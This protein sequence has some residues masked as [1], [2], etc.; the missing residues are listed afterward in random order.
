MA[1]ARP[2]VEG[3]AGS[4]RRRERLAKN[5]PNRFRAFE[6]WILLVRHGRRR[7]S[8]AKKILLPREPGGRWLVCIQIAGRFAGQGVSP[9][10]VEANWIDPDAKSCQ[11]CKDIPGDVRKG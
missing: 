8:P 1:V 3:G 5:A 6:L 10:A 7:R 9:I 2:P 11:A 4:T